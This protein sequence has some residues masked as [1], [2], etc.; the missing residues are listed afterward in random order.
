MRV[1]NNS[2]AQQG[3]RTV[4]GVVY[5]APGSTKDVEFTASGLEQARRRSFL[6][7]EEP[8]IVTKATIFDQTE[9]DTDPAS[10]PDA[11]QA[12]TSEPKKRGRPPKGS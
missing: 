5:I 6:L 10:E 2:S 4:S 3:V 11:D 1:T 12:I 7:I 9:S 8:I